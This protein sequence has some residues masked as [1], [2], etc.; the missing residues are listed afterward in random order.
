MPLT[1]F[2]SSPPLVFFMVSELYAQVLF[3]LRTL[4]NHNWLPWVLAISEGP[5]LRAA[6]S[7]QSSR[8][9]F[10][11][12]PPGLGGHWPFAQR[13]H[14]CFLSKDGNQGPWFQRG[15]PLL[16]STSVWRQL[17]N[18][19]AAQCLHGRKCFLIYSLPP[20]PRVSAEPSLM[21]VRGLH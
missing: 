3:G 6:S 1:V 10:A 4:T 12:R 17:W 21:G 13:I 11:S 20:P 18:G 15:H 2:I 14:W 7:L 8:F 19:L 5:L 9:C 16:S